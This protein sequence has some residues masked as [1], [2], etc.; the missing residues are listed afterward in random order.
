MLTNKLQ[1]SS[2]TFNSGVLNVLSAVDG[3]INSNILIGVNYGDRTVGFS[4]FFSAVSAGTEVEL[5]IAV[6][7]NNLINQQNIVEIRDFMFNT[8]NFY[9]IVQIQQKKDT[10]PPCLY[11][12]LKKTSINYVDNRGN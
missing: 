12:S 5:V 1:T 8:T 4:R 3:V 9:E 2:E 6:P 11:I 10:A 7:F